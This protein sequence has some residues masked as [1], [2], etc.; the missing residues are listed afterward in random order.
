MS[1]Q[2]EAELKANREKLQLIVQKMID[3]GEPDLKIKKAVE[4]YK[5]D[6]PIVATPVTGNSN[7]KA[8]GVFAESEKETPVMGPAEETEGST[9][10]ELEDGSSEFL[11][12]ARQDNTGIQIPDIIYD[13]KSSVENI[14]TFYSSKPELMLGEQQGQEELLTWAENQDLSLEGIQQEETEAR[15]GPELGYYNDESEE[16]EPSKIVSDQRKYL[17]Q[18]VDKNFFQNKNLL[19]SITNTETLTGY[20]RDD[21]NVKDLKQEIKSYIGYQS[22]GR[23]SFPLVSDGDIDEIIQESFGEYQELEVQKGIKKN[24]QDAISNAEKSGQETSSLVFDLEI[25][26]IDLHDKDEAE[27]ARINKRIRV[28]G[29]LPNLEE[30]RTELV[31]KLFYKDEVVYDPETKIAKATGRRVP[32]QS[33]GYKRYLDPAT[34]KVVG[35][36][37]AKI[38]EESGGEASEITTSYES[39]VSTFEGTPYG[40]LE[41]YNSDILLEEKGFD[42][43]G[44]GTIDVLV[45]DKLLNQ[46]LKKAGFESFLTDGKLTYKDV[47]VSFLTNN[48][49]RALSRNFAF[50][51]YD[52]SPT[53]FVE[54]E[55]DNPE[56][57]VEYL[58]NR[59]EQGLDIA[60]KKEALWQVYSL[61]RDYSTIEKTRLGQFGGEAIKVMDDFLGRGTAQETFGLTQQQLLD[62]V[63]QD[64]LPGMGINEDNKALFTTEAQR[65]HLEK[66]L[67]D[68]VTMGA[69]GFARMAPALVIGNKVQGLIGV[70]N[71]ARNMMGAKY[72]IKGARMNSGRAIAYA[73]KKG[74]TLE[75]MVEGGAAVASK[76]TRLERGSALGML[77]LAEDIKMREGM[78]ALSVDGE[79]AF[80]RGTGAAFLLGSK[81][82]PWSFKNFT[83]KNQLNTVLELSLKNAPAFTIAAEVG[84]FGK[85]MVNDLRG[86]EE[87]NTFIKENWSDFSEVAH[88]GIEHMIFGGMLGLHG[89]KSKDIQTYEAI[90]KTKREAQTLRN[91]TEIKIKQG[92]DEYLRSK[93]EQEGVIYKGQSIHVTDAN[94]QQGKKIKKFRK[95]NYTVTKYQEWLSNQSEGSKISK[96][97]DDFQTYQQDFYAA[98]NYLDRAD[99]VEAWTDPIK[100][101]KLYEEQHKELKEFATSKGKEF[102]YEL[103]DKPIYQEYVS[104]NGETKYQEVNALYTR[105][106][107]SKDPYKII[108]NTKKSK[109]RGT[110][111]H[112]MLH[113]YEDIL[114]EGSPGME[115]QYV[116]ALKKRMQ[117]VEIVQGG[118]KTN[119]YDAVLSDAAISKMTDPT[120]FME[121]RAYTAEYL[122]KKENQH[123]IDSRA[124]S[125][126]GGFFNNMSK[127]L[128]GKPLDVFTQRELVNMLGRYGSTGRISELKH[129]DQYLDIGKKPTEAQMASRD[130]TLEKQELIDVNKELFKNKPK[131]W[132]KIKDKNVKQIKKLNENIDRSERNAKNI[133]IYQRLEPGDLFRQRAEN[134]LV[135]DNMGIIGDFIKS[136]FKKGL[137]VSLS[138]FEAGTYMQ[139]AKIMNR[140][141]ASTGVPFGAYLKQSLG[142][143][144]TKSGFSQLGNI[145]KAEQAGRT[146][147]IAMSEVG[148]DAETLQIAD[149][150]P[151]LS[152]SGSEGPKGREL[153]RDLNIPEDV[154]NK[155][156]ERLADLDVSQLTYKT[157][158]DLVPEYTNEILGVEPKAGNLGKGSVANAQKW[159]SKDSN[160]RLFIDALPEGTIPMEGAPELVKGTS[161]G[162]QNTLLKEF[163]NSGGRVKTKAGAVIQNKIKGITPRDVKAFFGI[164]P[165]GS[166]IELKN[167]RGL[168][169]KVKAAVDQ[170]GKAWT[171]QVAREYLKNNSPQFELST[172]VENLINQVEAGKSESL[173]SKDLGRQSVETQKEVFR[174]VIS[175]EFAKIFNANISGYGKTDK[176]VIES[177]RQYFKD[178]DINLKL[179]TS[180]GKP[181]SKNMLLASIANQ[182]S[183]SLKL[184][185]YKPNNIAIKIGNRILKSNEYSAVEAMNGLQPLGNPFGNKAG[186]IKG[187][188]VEYLLA[189]KL[190][191]KYGNGF[192]EA[193]LKNGAYTGS[194][195]GSYKSSEVVVKGLHDIIFGKEYGGT[196]PS[197]FVTSGDYT[198]NVSEPI[199]KRVNKKWGG[200]KPA[201]Y[202][203]NKEVLLKKWV[204]GSLNK[205]EAYEL[206]EQNKNVLRESIEILNEAYEKGDITHEHVRAFTQLHSASMVG[207]IKSSA[208]LAILPKGKPKDFIK[209]YGKDWVLEHTTPAK[210]IS[211][212]IYDY[213]TTPD[214]SRKVQLKDWVKNALD[215]YHTTLIPEKLDRMVNEIY[216]ESLPPETLFDGKSD[217]VTDRYH[218]DAF[219]EG[220]D[221]P[222]ENFVNG[223]VYEKLPGVNQVELARKGK[224]LREYQKALFPKGYKE[225][226]AS[227]DLS[228]AIKNVDK[229][230]ELGRKKN[231]KG[232]GMATFDFDETLIIEGE[233]TVVAKKGKETVKI[234]SSNWPIEGPKYAERGFE[235]D[236]SDFANVRGG[237]EGPLLQKMKN[238]IAKH[239]P[240]DVFVLTARQQ[241]AAVPIHQWLKIQGID[242]PLE[243]ITGLGKSQGEAK[244][245]WMLEKFAE[246]YNDMYFVDDALPNVEAV[247]KV[248][249]QLDI[250]SKVQLALASKDLNMGVNDIMKHSLDIAPEKIFSKA[251]AKIRGANI[252][253]RRIFMTDAAADLELLLEPLYGKGSKGTENKKWFGENFVRLFERGHND[254]N[255]ARQ[256][257]ANGYMALRKQNK[258][259]VKSLDQP[260]EGTSFTTDMALR[261][262]IWNKNGMKI[263]GLAKASEAK[264]VEHVRNNP[265]LQAFAENVARLTGIETGLREPSGNWWAETIASEMGSL[266]EGVG[267][268]KYLQ[269]WMDAKNEIFSEENLNKM[270]TKL[271]S[272]WRENLEEM[273]YRMETGKTRRADLGK[274]GNAMMD[275]LNG[276]VGTIMNLNTRSATLQL[277]SSVNFINHDFNNPLLA[278]KAF[279]NQKQY[280]KDFAYILN[281]DMLKQRRSGLQINVTE[282]ELAAAASGQKNKAKAVL[283]WILK[284]GYVPTKICDSFAIASGGATYYRNAIRK[285][286]KEGLSKAEAE[287][288]AWIDFQ[289]VAERTQQSSRPDLLS[290]QQ[291]SVGGRIILPFAN[292]PMQM[293]RIMMKE[294]LD[295]KNGRYKGFTGDNSIT[296]KMSK[297]GYYGFVQ[298]AIFAGLQS[299][300]FALMMNSDDDE[301]I[302]NKKVR[303]VNTI[304]DSFLRGMGIQG[305]VLSGLKN[306]ILEFKKQNDKSWGSDYDEV[307]EDLLNISPTVGSKV[308]KL[309][310]A[311]NTYQWNKKEILNDGLTLDGPALESLT[312]ATEALLNIPVNRVHRK[313][314]N[315]IEALDS[316]NEAWQRVMVG[317]GWSQWDVG[318]GQRK[319]AEEKATKDE[320]KKVEKEQEKVAAKKQVEEEKKAEEQKKKDEGFKNVRCSGTKSNGSRC[321]ITIETKA[322]SA[323]CTYHKSYKPNEGSDRNNNGVKEYQCKSLTGSGKRCKNRSENANK[324]CYAH[325]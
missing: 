219:G 254:I 225:A 218:A 275:Y 228:K 184:Q 29:S 80:E 10:L 179:E 160:A 195:L 203:T 257:A 66:T 130:L 288:K 50:S 245:L 142:G 1:T 247:K 141:D 69:G 19:S 226:L 44:E 135:A 152:R 56:E 187:R 230:F 62:V 68:S 315:I 164:R 191:T 166:F 41:K 82:A 24:I 100:G 122:S 274:A 70:T 60:A 8:V 4:L 258:K 42:I 296:N 253:R 272:D 193:F 217:V 112:D 52:V 153:V 270:E 5:Q 306:S 98:Q 115:T 252:K 126:V 20:L 31:D 204:N 108:Y 139:V 34:G 120:K 239:G 43:E 159:F 30:R 127:S 109:G 250:K 83:S 295:I 309:D 185:G 132:E 21:S 51:D 84:E 171:N 237:K 278:A 256:K 151:E 156:E 161:T 169:Q 232:R 162:V 61:N 103:T 124:Y 202:I 88:R 87:F 16:V 320:A 308:G 268:E 235:F 199:A 133:E 259:V 140:Y 22:D 147:E 242:I 198:A 214:I 222:L 90:G 212:L 265:E 6:S 148:V 125:V 18:Y 223:K 146:T 168:G 240:K 216:Q 118:N 227:K 53:N 277:I 114:F 78:G 27:L 311:G 75:K 273:F 220:F 37:E 116:E 117:Q 119:L 48:T 186:I 291:V 45:G 188:E 192:A 175:P 113:V 58:K 280:W 123:L 323:K 206:G 211:T 293:N 243:N 246:G 302:A 154:I 107:T 26:E 322:K 316:K 229:A 298:S 86:V 110:I 289:A 300:L 304:A 172:S 136:E 294:L 14:N 102:Q 231:K 93:A 72:I 284:Q 305:A 178:K 94:R 7:D 15:L 307:Y 205:M 174:G 12:P 264:L 292:T 47:P 157:L 318:I 312:M 170:I 99:D 286:T 314:G 194:G 210:E 266:G 9:D 92:F 176:T 55:Y 196:R 267:R 138:D 236:F 23:Q 190:N 85:A 319:K 248:L 197:Y 40:Q 208:S 301:L 299:G 207:L 167:D 215:N 173:A 180:T 25:A 260:V 111:S 143:K 181:I 290:A 276:S 67:L 77:A 165:D 33:G 177:F 251:E 183:G 269:D 249:D 96:L 81:L 105:P 155:A 97:V 17:K 325:Q 11:E 233:N 128:L 63:D 261:T 59:K 74:T 137:D 36:K 189:E 49:P 144:H 221:I 310:A 46:Q 303:S 150:S 283:A 163:Y 224:R 35:T 244:A 313:I 271:G 263:P 129:L 200:K 297:V 28:N 13:P 285:Y 57:F 255:N 131:D 79:L 39:Y 3:A 95:E 158:K 324:K 238:L 209:Q 262:Y 149:T 121:L 2:S 321:N 182:L 38:I 64:I 287:R 279:A 54:G 76:A 73:A 145:L 282:A 101:E 91:R 65:T 317:L 213:I 281:S 234:S 71:M 32:K 106:K 134:T 241:D 89:L 201:S 104:A